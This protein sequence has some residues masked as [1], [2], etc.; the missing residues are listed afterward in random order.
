MPADKNLLQEQVVQTLERNVLLLAPAGTG[1]TATL[2]RRI[3]NVLNRGFATADQILCLTFTNRACKEIRERVL[4]VANGQARQVHVRTFHSLC[5]EVIRQEAKRETDIPEE[6]LIFDEIDCLELIKSL[7]QNPDTASVL[8]KFI[9]LVKSN[10]IV[11]GQKTLQQIIQDLTDRPLNPI[12]R[13]CTSNQGQLDRELYDNLLDFGDKLVQK[14]DQALREQGAL[15]FNDLQIEAYRLFEDPEIADR[16][17]AR[18]RFIHV[19]EVQDTSLAEYS[20]LSKIFHHS[21]ILICGDYFQTIYQWRGSN[22]ETVFDG[23]IENYDP[24]EISFRKNYRATAKLLQ[25]AHGYLL[26]AFQTATLDRFHTPKL[27]IFSPTPGDPVEIAGFEEL[28]DEA[29]WIYQQIQQQPNQRVAVLTRTNWMSSTLS[30]FFQAFNQSQPESR[31]LNFFTVEQFKFFRRQEI[32]DLLAYLK[33][34]VNKYDDQSLQRIL[35]RFFQTAGNRA[36]NLSRKAEYRQSGLRLIDLVDPVT[37]EHGEPYSRLISA[38]DDQRV[39]VFDVETNGRDFLRSE[40]IQIAAIKIDARGRELDRF[41]RY[42]KIAGSVGLTEHIHHISDQHLATHGRPPA[43]ALSEFAEFIRDCHIVGHNVQFDIDM[44]RSQLIRYQLP[45]D[46]PI[47]FDDT[48]N[49]SRR[50]LPGLKNYKLETLCQHYQTATRADHN[51]LND[52]LA[53]GEILVKLINQ[54]LRPTEEQRRRL[55]APLA[56]KFET[57]TRQLEI[58][59]NP[60]ENFRPLERLDQIIELSNIRQV[61]RGEEHRWENIQE[62]RR[63]VAAFDNR[64]NHGFHSL[65][66]LLQISA[67]SNTE[68]DRLT[69]NASE[70]PRIPIITVHQAKGAE[71]DWVF[72]AGAHES[73]YPSYS[74]VR[75]GRELEERR[76]F[77][78]GL[79]RARKKLS[80]SWSKSQWI[81]SESPYLDLIPVE[82]VQRL[83]TRSEN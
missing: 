14:Y 47:P 35:K 20:I 29:H 39:V 63:I 23:F 48:V 1:K 15:D 10:R 72:L 2:A 45:L 50:F 81:Q 3:A 5:C 34:M 74:S 8:Q 42:L 59:R 61:Y 18:Y 56:G 73:G 53:T 79:T 40:I 32:K 36:V 71:F 28:Q 46:Q 82:V 49:L 76:L 58:L 31:R 43:E 17:A 44:F 41:E 9:E 62:F 67:L 21:R 27:E 19:D 26:N 25:A 16:W 64:E 6:F 4:G 11:D 78:V 60:A 52:V 51:A 38:L 66:D 77:Y 69:A 30:D 37:A 55:L 54:H 24:V 80:I 75:E 7:I 70:P 12:H 65:R 13:I 83:E 57:L 68:L 33:L 22:P